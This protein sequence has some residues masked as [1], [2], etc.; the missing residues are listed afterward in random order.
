LPT[1]RLDQGP[2]QDKLRSL[3]TY[4]LEDASKFE[5]LLDGSGA[6]YDDPVLQAYLDGL[7]QPLLPRVDPSSSYHIHLK[8][9][10]DSTL[11]AFTLG[12]GSIY[13]NTGLIARLTSAE[14]FAFVMGHEITHVMNRDLVYF[15]DSYQRKTVATK[16]TELV[17][18]PAL[19]TVGLSGVGELGLS[20]AYLASVTGFG[21]EREAAADQESL[22]VMQQLG[23]ELREAQRIFEIF[24]AEHERYERGIEVGFLSSYPS[25]T[26]R[27]KAVKA[28]MGARALDV[29]APP[30]EDAAFLE[31]TH[32]LRVDN[33]AFNLQLGRYYHAVEDLQVILRRKPEDASAH[34]YLAE[35]YRL[36][37]E[38]PK[39]LKDELNRS[40]W[41]QMSQ[42]A[43]QEQTP[44]WQG[45]AR[46]EYTAAMTLDPRNPQ[47]YRGMGLLLMAQGQ[48]D[49]ALKQFERYLQ[50]APDA[51]DRRFVLAQ[52]ERIRDAPAT[53][54][55]P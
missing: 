22:A 54:E 27:L 16:L 41:R 28:S 39:K 48:S 46:E 14:Q 15:T 32:Q 10:R 37:A 8:V 9:I 25:N 40:T 11:N 53:E 24:L 19:A 51:K 1:V 52:I 23:Y 3:E 33:A 49:E 42:I 30:K 18:S 36:I 47:P 20:M 29:F 31:A 26:E 43:D 2:V 35:A 50:V 44:Y 21:R 55:G 34:F 5:E 12:N 45:R 7:T 13:F 6:V 4:V 17:L 38:D